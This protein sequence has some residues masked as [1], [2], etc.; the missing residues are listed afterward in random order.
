VSTRIYAVSNE[1]EY[2]LV[3]ATTRSAAVRHVAQRRYEVNIATAKD[4]V[5]AMNA[6]VK[7]EVAGDA[8]DL[9]EMAQAA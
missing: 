9:V 1:N 5:G 2:Y 6:G 7:V 8:P 4:I 3:E